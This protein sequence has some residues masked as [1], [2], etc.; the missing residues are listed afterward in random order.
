ML[1]TT[2]AKQLAYVEAINKLE[3][4]IVAQG[5]VEILNSGT[6]KISG[7]NLAVSS[8]SVEVNGEIPK[9]KKVDGDTIFWFDLEAGETA[10]IRYW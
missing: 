4:N 2:I 10:I 3:Y 8:H 5:H 1:P 6:Q 9:S 7:L